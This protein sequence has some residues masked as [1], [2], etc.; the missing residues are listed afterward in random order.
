M[1]IYIDCVDLFPLTRLS[2][3]EPYKFLQ[4]IT[5]KAWSQYFNKQL[6][7]NYSVRLRIWLSNVLHCRD[8]KHIMSDQYSI[9][10]SSDKL[11]ISFQS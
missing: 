1:L 8:Q 6:N 5:Q 3:K 9:L 11:G 4:A 2:C 10:V 7:Q